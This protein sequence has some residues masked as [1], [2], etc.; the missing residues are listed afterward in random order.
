VVGI[1]SLKDVVAHL[2]SFEEVL[3][4]ILA[5]LRDAS[6]STPTLEQF[7]HN[8]DFNNTQVAQREHKTP[9]GILAQ[10]QDWHRQGLEQIAQLPEAKLKERGLL[11]WYGAE[12]D[13]EDFLV[14]SYYGH[15]REHS[16][17]IALYK[18]RL[19]QA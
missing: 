12:Y 9:A 13:L 18:K 6:T 3:A 15:K 10:Y 5:S 8:P 2:A 1:W 4:E 19:A 11:P 17:Q 16:A 7:I 14:Y